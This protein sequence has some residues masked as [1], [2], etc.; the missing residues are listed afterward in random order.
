MHVPQAG[1]LPV[2][3]LQVACRW[4]LGRYAMRLAGASFDSLVPGSVVAIR[5]STGLA[6]GDAF[7]TYEPS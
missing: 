7:G 6:T 5:P 2:L 1:P 4:V 3:V